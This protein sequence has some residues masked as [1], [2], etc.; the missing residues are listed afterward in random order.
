VNFSERILSLL[1]KMKV[2]NQVLVNLLHDI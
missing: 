2:L 1:D